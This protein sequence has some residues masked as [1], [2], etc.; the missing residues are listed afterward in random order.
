MS[1]N[2]APH[3]SFAGALCIAM[4]LTPLCLRPWSF[5]Q[6][7]PRPQDARITYCVLRGGTPTDCAAALGAMQSAPK[8]EGPPRNSQRASDILREFG[9]LGTWALNCR[10]PASSD[11]AY[12]VYAAMDDGNAR[13]TYY[14]TPDRRTSSSTYVIIAATRAS[15]DQISYR[16]E[17]TVFHDRMN[18]VML[19]QGNRLQVRSSVRDPGVVLV[20]D[21]VFLGSGAESPWQAKCS[22]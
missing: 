8:D 10:E 12:S 20:K 18:I 17:G 11:N 9:I 1:R 15:S 16:Q 2:F 22:E 5:A 19:K 3:W 21:G 7:Q 6:A 4:V 14:T 13:R